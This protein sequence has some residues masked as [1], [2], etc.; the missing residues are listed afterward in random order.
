MPVNYI[1]I[2]YFLSSSARIV[3]VWIICVW[4]VRSGAVAHAVAVSSIV[5]ALG[6][7]GIHCVRVIYSVVILRWGLWVRVCVIVRVWVSVWVVIVRVIRIVGLVRIIAVVHILRNVV[8]WN[9]RFIDQ[10]TK[11]VIEFL[12]IDFTIEILID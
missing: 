7:V 1:K 5:W 8:L 2:K 3:I 6:R 12:F 11:S 9:L 4:V 10:Q